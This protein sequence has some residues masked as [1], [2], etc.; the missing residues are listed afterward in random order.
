M[1]E[2][3]NSA[4][5]LSS[6]TAAESLLAK[7]IDG[8][9]WNG[10]G[11]IIPLTR[12]AIDRLIQFGFTIPPE[13]FDLLDHKERQLAYVADLRDGK[14]EPPDRAM[15][16]KGEPYHHQRVAHAIAMEL[17]DQEYPT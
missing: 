4:L 6:P 7:Q 17:F 3:S 15:P 12:E 8:R 1:L 11:W 2:L 5:V 16:V 10:S 14:V 13:A 9:S